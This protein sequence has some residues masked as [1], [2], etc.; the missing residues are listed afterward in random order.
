MSV[1]STDQQFLIWKKICKGEEADL[2][3]IGVLV[4]NIERNKVQYREALDFLQ[5][6]DH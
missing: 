2:I 5:K 1:P 6:N 3:I 4:E